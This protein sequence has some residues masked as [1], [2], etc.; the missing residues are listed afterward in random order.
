MNDVS[1]TGPQPIRRRPESGFA[2]WQMTLGHINTYL[3]P[4]VM[5]QLQ[6][7]PG[8]GE[9]GGISWVA[10]LSWGQNRE[11]VAGVESLAAAFRQLWLEVDRH[12]VI[13][14]DPQDAI[15]APGGYEDHEWLEVSAQEILHR[16]LWTSR[17]VFDRDWSLIVVYQPSDI[18]AMRVQMRL[19]ARENSVYVGGRGPSLLDAARTLYRNAAPVYLA[20]VDSDGELPDLTDYSSSDYSV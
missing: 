8:E 18:P 13:F 17:I 2:A 9:D 20:H 19:L 16:I 4:D 11:T 1:P 14:E 6:A 12:H 3:S 5:L 15:R 7:H 10:T